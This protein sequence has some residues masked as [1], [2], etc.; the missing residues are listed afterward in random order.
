MPRKPL[1]SKSDS[2][3]GGRW[4]KMKQVNSKQLKSYGYVSM[5]V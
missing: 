3:M 5:G 4:N 1:T 2:K